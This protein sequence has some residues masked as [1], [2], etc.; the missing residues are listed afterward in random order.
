VVAN[1]FNTNREIIDNL[2]PFP[3]TSTRVCSDTRFIYN[4][5]DAAI[6][7]N[8]IVCFPSTPDLFERSFFPAFRR[9]QHYVAGVRALWAPLVAGANV[10]PDIELDL[11]GFGI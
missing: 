1:H 2:I 11:I 3:V 7:A 5:V 4:P 9:M 6:Q 8:N 10:I